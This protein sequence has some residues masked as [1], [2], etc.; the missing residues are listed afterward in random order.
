MFE[1]ASSFSFPEPA[2]AEGIAWF[3]KIPFLCIKA[4]LSNEKIRSHPIEY[5]PESL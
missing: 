3:L 1:L 5:S 4:T 2:P